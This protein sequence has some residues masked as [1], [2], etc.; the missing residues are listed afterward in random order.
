[1][2]NNGFFYIITEYCKGGDLR[3]VFQDSDESEE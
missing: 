2:K 1:M 3:N